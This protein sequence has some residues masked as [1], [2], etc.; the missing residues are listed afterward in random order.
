AYEAARATIA[1]FVGAPDDEVVFTKNA[2]EA[3]T[4]VA[5]AKSYAVPAGDEFSRFAV[6][7][8]HVIVATDTEHDAHLV[9]WQELCRRTGA[10]L[11]WFGVTDEGRLDLSNLDDLINERTKLVALIHQSNVLGTVNPVQLIAER[12]HAVGALVLVDGAQS[13]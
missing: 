2:T 12:A 8:G 11:R 1:A 5:Y 10:T 4:L 7:P 6:Q 9:P 13:V 3:I